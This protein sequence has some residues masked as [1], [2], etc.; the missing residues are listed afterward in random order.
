VKTF[1]KDAMSTT[2]VETNEYTANGRVGMMAV[3]KKILDGHCK[4]KVTIHVSS[5]REKWMRL[6]VRLCVLVCACACSF[7]CET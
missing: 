7:D 5:D 1:V 2:R 6:C 4:I 3:E